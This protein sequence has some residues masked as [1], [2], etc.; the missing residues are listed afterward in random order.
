[1]KIAIKALA[2]AFSLAA[3]STAYGATD[4]AGDQIKRADAEYKIAKQRCDAL[5]GNEA[6][7]C[8]KEAKAT[9][10]KTKADAR[11]A[12]KGTPESRA[13]AGET[14]A[15]ADYKAQMERCEALKGKEADACESRAKA[16]LDSRQAKSDKVR[17]TN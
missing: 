10:D 17:K 11:A 4:V 16:T 9:R 13:D 2:V 1:M 5:K 12:R 3:F 14:K 7:V 6:D 8:D 15:K